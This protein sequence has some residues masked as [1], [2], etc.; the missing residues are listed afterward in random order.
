MPYNPTED[1][2]EELSHHLMQTPYD[3]DSTHREKF[4]IDHLKEVVDDWSI[5]DLSY[6]EMIREFQGENLG[7][8]DIH[9][10]LREMSEEG[11]YD[12]TALD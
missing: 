3:P 5:G 11:H 6:D 2:R 8:F 7:N 1:L 4:L 10:W 12:L 9:Q